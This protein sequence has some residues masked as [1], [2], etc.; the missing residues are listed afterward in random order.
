MTTTHDVVASLGHAI[1]QR[2]GE[3]RYRLWFANNVR[4]QVNEGRLQVGFPNRFFQD[5]LQTTYA[6]EVAEAVRE[7]LGRSIEP[8][9]VIDP[10]LFQSFRARQQAPAEPAPAAPLPAPVQRRGPPGFGVGT[11]HRPWLELAEFVTGPGNRL[12]YEAARRVIAGGEAF[13][14][15]LVIHGP[16]G[17]GKTHLLE[18]IAAGLSRPGDRGRPVLLTA[19]EFTNRFIHALHDKA[20]RER[21]LAEFRR[22]LRLADA[23]LVDDVQFFAHKKATQAEFLHTF[24]A[25]VQ[26]GRPVVLAC[27]RHPRSIDHLLP[28][29]V[30]RLL[31]GVTV[32]L[33]PPDGVTRAALLK[34][35]AARLGCELPDDVAGFLAQRLRGNIRELEGAVHAVHH[36]SLTLDRPVTL[37]LA[38]SA[39]ANLLRPGL[40]G[41]ALRDIEQALCSVLGLEVRVLHSETKA[42]AISRCRMLAMHLMRKHVQWAYSAIGKHFARNHSTALA[43]D[44]KV[45]TWLADGKALSIGGQRWNLQALIEQVERHL[46]APG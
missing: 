30:D 23:L 42:Q 44:K 6:S 12:A 35:R 3:A 5:W 29:L 26:R 28:E 43:A 15:P 24:E 18:G 38:Q 33:E 41:P 16:V 25:L 4:L 17:L 21:R 37:E 8:E 14:N 45:R 27:D 13:P 31:G 10:E 22:Q 7:V 39:A 2:I 34:A 40:Q 46:G 20:S 1:A 36:H 19:E 11:G 9:Y 32:S